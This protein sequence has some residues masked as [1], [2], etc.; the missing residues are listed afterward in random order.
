[1]RDSGPNWAVPL[2]ADGWQLL[3]SL[4]VVVLTT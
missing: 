4:M 3:H 2:V 1:M